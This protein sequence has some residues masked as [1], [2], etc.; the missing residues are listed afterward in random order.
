[1]RRFIATIMATMLILSSCHS[2]SQQDEAEES[3]ARVVSN[4]LSNHFVY[5]IAEDGNGMIWFGTFRGLNKFNSKN[6]FQYFST[7]DTTSI[8]DNNV[9]KVFLDSRK[10]LWIGTVNG[11]CRYT[12]YDRFVRLKGAGSQRFINNIVETPD[13]SLFF[14]SQYGMLSR[15]DSAGDSLRTVIPNVGNTMFFSNKVHPAEGAN[16]WL[17]TPL[18]VKYVDT[19]RGALTDS[20]PTGGFI[21]DSYSPFPNELWLVGPGALKIFDMR[22]RKF[23]ELPRQLATHPVLSQSTPEIIHPYGEDGVLILTATDG[24]FLFNRSTGEVLHQKEDGF[25]FQVPP[26][27]ISTIFTDSRKNLWFG[28]DDQG[29][30]VHYHN[31]ERFNNNNFLRT[32]LQ[33]KSVISVAADGDHR[34]WALTK[35]DGIYI[36]DTKQQHLINIP[37]GVICG[38]RGKNATSMYAAHDGTMWV[39]NSDRELLQCALQGTTLGIKRRHT[40]DSNVMSLYEDSNGTMWV[41]TF[42]PFMYAIPREGEPQRLQVFDGFCFIPGLAQFD[43]NHLLV[44]GLKQPFKL[45]DI[46]TCEISLAPMKGGEY[47]NAVKRSIFIPTAVKSGRHNDF[48]IGT[49]ANGLLHYL[50]ASGTIEP[51]KGITCNDIS[52]LETDGSGNLWIGTLNGLARY[53]PDSL[54]VT[55]FH[56]GDGIGGDQFYDRS[57]C[58]APSGEIVFGGTHGI[59]FFRPRDVKD[60]PVLPLYFE[61]LKVNN[62]IVYPGED[63]PI[64]KHLSAFP[65]VDLEH[66]QNSISISFVPLDY[67]DSRRVD[68]Q[69]QLE[70]VDAGWRDAD[71]NYEASYAKLKPGN[72]TFRVRIMDAYRK[73][74]LAAISLR[75]HIASPWWGT[76]WARLLYLGVFVGIGWAAWRVRHRINNERRAVAKERM[77]KEQEKRVNDMNMR[78]FANISHEFRTPLTMIAGPVAQL[79]DTPDLSSDKKRLLTVVRTNVDRML[80]L[81]NQLLDFNKLENDALR[82]KVRRIDVADILQRIN[83][84]FELSSDQKQIEWTTTG[85]D[86]PLPAWIDEDKLIKIY[87]NLLSNALKHTPRGGH[88]STSVDIA[89]E[90]GVQCVKIVVENTGRSIPDDKLEVIFERFYQLDDNDDVSVNGGTGIGLYYCRR[91]AT[92][93]HGAVRAVSHRGG[94]RFEVLLPLEEGAYSSEERDKSPSSQLVLY[95]L[96]T[97]M[98]NEDEFT[99]PPSDETPTILVVDDDSD[100]AYYMKL[101]LSPHYRVVTC[102]DGDSALEWLKANTAALIISDVVM[103]GRDGLSLCRQIKEDFELCHIPLILVTAQATVEH[104]VEG[105]EAQADAYVTKPFN[106]EFMLSLVKSLL[107]NREKIR[108]LVNQTTTVEDVSPEILSPQ[109]NAFL[110]DL[111]SIMEQEISNQ[112]LDINDI[113]R[114]L[115]ISR[116]KFYYKVKGLTGEAPGG[117]FKTYKLNRAAQL[118][119]EGHH[120]ISEIADLTG[121]GSLST[122]SRAFKKHFGV[123]PTE[124]KAPTDSS[125]I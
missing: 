106:P 125:G 33:D 91:L 4:Q 85:M 49:V 20:I 43:S 112:E 48:Y 54:V 1:M 40:L 11:V 68:C 98:V 76:W 27:K 63:Q 46:N 80:Q 110:S 26:F 24:M 9:H 13:S 97:E 72:Y 59:T 77:E 101:L 104:Q 100:V 79:S 35:Y 116:T 42:S 53:E 62:S 96:R 52:S 115:C 86:T 107:L 29:Y 81:V 102:F 28:S 34:L 60:T 14:L 119:L 74:A 15:Y 10:R 109:D 32:K 55:E 30:A 65:D 82:L 111:Y 56:A 93:H 122:F 23:K 51:I 88:I 21:V 113:S 38:P 95:P 6:F 25:P 123:A 39:G 58:S 5:S 71:G 124:Y 64:R 87:T 31:Q 16:L 41:G 18:A 67:A 73:N 36:Y 84:S 83:S 114:R 70:G 44:L 50:P 99:S 12:D 17:V 66:D 22:S 19:A 117:F 45:V 69:Y 61:N 108:K 2:S 57:S 90:Q 94:A 92:L 103:P 89:V 8:T 7:N 120:T 78:F 3:P 75:I 118:I 47:E 105:L 121:F 37:Q